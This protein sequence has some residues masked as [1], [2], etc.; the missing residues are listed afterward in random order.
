MVPTHKRLIKIHFFITTSFLDNMSSSNT[1]SEHDEPENNKN[2]ISK[3]E[4]N[5]KYSS[6]KESKKSSPSKK[7]NKKNFSS[8]NLRPTQ[9]EFVDSVNDLVTIPVVT[10]YIKPGESY[11]SLVDKASKLLQDGDFLVIS[12]TPIAISQGRLVDEAQFKPSLISVLL[13]DVWS[14][15]IWGYI[16]GPLLR[17]K[18]RTIQNL[19]RLPKEAR[20]HKQLILEYYGIKHALK[21]ASEAGVDLSNVPGT[22]VCL[23]P[24]N[25][26]DVVEDIHKK[27]E[28]KY[29]KDVTVMIIDTDATYQLGSTKFTS[30]PLAIP[31]I[32]KDLGFFGYILG[33]V[34]KIKG[35]TPL[36][37][38]NNNDL[39]KIMAIA[40]LAE[41]YQEKKEDNME[42]IYDMQ[43]TF[44]K[45]LNGV[46]IEM[47]ESIKHTPA[48]IVRKAS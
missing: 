5:K 31:G 11:D 43:K 16:L 8:R 2:S 24:E 45:D 27:L 9:K 36:A 39:D 25:P 21:P 26:Q 32:K 42:T 29:K 3:L 38:S 22:C 47:L 40:K 12:E 6:K 46:T 15:Y 20:S 30:I 37:V 23:L 10:G 34:A 18:S 19:R 13:A 35:P 17:I 1:S 41:D 14:K 33:R 44:H 48:V 28:S 7:E 4:N